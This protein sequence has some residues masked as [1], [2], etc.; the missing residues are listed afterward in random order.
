MIKLYISNSTGTLDITE[1]VQT[2]TWS[3][4]YQQCS[5]TLEFE[6]VSSQTDK[7][8][9]KVK[10]ELG[11]G[12]ILMQDNRV[13]FDGFIFE[14]QKTS[15]SSAISITCYDRGF[16]LKRNEASYRFPGMTPETITKRIC[17]DFGIETGSIAS[18]NIIIERNF[19]GVSLYNII[20]T[21]YTLASEAT[22]KKYMLRFNGAKLNVIEKAVTNE[23]LVIEGGSNLMSASTTESIANMINQVVI[24]NEDDKLV[25]TQK[26]TAAIK[27][28]GVLQ[29]YLKQSKGEKGI[30]KAKTLIADNGASQKITIES[31][32]NIANI[33]GGTVVVREPY[34][35]VYGQFY[36][37]ND[38]HT[39]KRGQYYNKLVVNFKNIM[40][41]Q[42]VGTLP[43]KDGSKT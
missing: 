33:T 10:C 19:I 7:R 24:Y 8:V 9:P 35:G 15:G 17:S 14:R 21:A 3:G 31:L 6:L 23:T 38:I 43:N 11:Y 13:L 12:A 27:L 18:P 39:W 34:T 4:D 25:A 37:D 22:G 2:I 1:L 20:Q 30:E 41:E 36:I 42:E 26:D 5:R 28:Y 32:G 16:Y 40:D 29:S